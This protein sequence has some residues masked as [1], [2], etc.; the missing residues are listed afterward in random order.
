MKFVCKPTLNVQIWGIIFN[1]FAVIPVSFCLLFGA[2]V[3]KWDPGPKNLEK[4][5]PKTITKTL[6][7]QCFEHLAMFKTKRR[8]RFGHFYVVMFFY[9][10]SF[11]V[12]TSVFLIFYCIYLCF[13]QIV[14]V[15]RPYIYIER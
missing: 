14:F 12:R 13:F 10:L 4:G 6:Y 9:G 11:F 3:V 7:L 15:N 2:V 1:T 8:S 5:Y